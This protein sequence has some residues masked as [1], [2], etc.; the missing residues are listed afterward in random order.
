MPNKQLQPEMFYPHHTKNT[1]A[2]LPAL[3]YF[4]RSH[5][6]AIATSNGNSV[7]GAKGKLF[8][9][10]PSIGKI[11]K[12]KLF[13]LNRRVE[14]AKGEFQFRYFDFADPRWRQGHSPRAEF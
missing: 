14:S 7:I 9:G 10:E 1:V 12:K 2:C 13:F 5:G 4:Y 8:I 6:N 3:S 11:S